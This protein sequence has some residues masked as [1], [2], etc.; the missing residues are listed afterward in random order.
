MKRKL[1]WYPGIHSNL[2]HL[3][4]AYTGKALCGS[5]ARRKEFRGP[6]YWQNSDCHICKSYAAEREVCSVSNVDRMAT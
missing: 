3:Y 5:R 2:N 4:D 1:A 6:N